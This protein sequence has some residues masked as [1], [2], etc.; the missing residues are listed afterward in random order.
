MAID[1]LFPFSVHRMDFQS[2]YHFFVM[3]TSLIHAVPFV[4][5]V[6]FRKLEGHMSLII[7]FFKEHNFYD[8]TVIYTWYFLSGMGFFLFFKK[9]GLLIELKVGS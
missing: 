7:L 9:L 5:D 3:F 4:L 6:F 8:K 2:I 1:F